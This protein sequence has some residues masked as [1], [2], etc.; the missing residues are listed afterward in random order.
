MADNTRRDARTPNSA[1]RDKTEGTAREM[2]GR[3]KESFGALTGNERLEAQGREDQVAGAARRK[4]GAWKDRIK[5]WI[6]RR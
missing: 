5:A 4:K 3:A 2:R 1:A 6:D